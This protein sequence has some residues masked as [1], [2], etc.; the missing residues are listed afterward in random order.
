MGEQAELNED[1][2]DLLRSLIA[3]RVEFV[4]VDAHALAAHG[5][6][7]ATGDLD[8]FVEP[9]PENAERVIEALRAFGAPLDAHGVSRADFE[10]PDNVYQVGLPPGRI[11]LMTSI[12]GVSFAEARAT[13]IVIDLASMKLPVLGRDALVKNKRATG[14]PKDI[15]DADALEG[16]TQ[17]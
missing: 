17:R 13:R 4:I 2:V 11:D 16:S 7:R 15:V 1:F 10:A 12:S 5:L 3:A 9:S 14:R 8:V 6:P